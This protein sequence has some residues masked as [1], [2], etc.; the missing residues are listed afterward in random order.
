MIFYEIVVVVKKRNVVM[1]GWLEIRGIPRLK[2][3]AQQR[4]S[5]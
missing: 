1:R 5:F 2:S 3:S 4:A